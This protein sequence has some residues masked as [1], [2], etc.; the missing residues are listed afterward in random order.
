M[1]DPILGAYLVYFGPPQRW[2]M[3]RNVKFDIRIKILV[4]ISPY[5][6]ILVKI[7]AVIIYACMT[8]FWK[9]IWCTLA[10]PSGGPCG[11]I[12]NLTSELKSSYQF[13]SMD[14]FW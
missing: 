4:P 7:G 1:Y 12:L 13:H 3:W 9:P 8:P 6:S 10:H 14:Q 5:G 2:P 11:G